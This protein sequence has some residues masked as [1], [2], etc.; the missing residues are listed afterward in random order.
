MAYKRKTFRG[1]MREA[2]TGDGRMNLD[3]AVQREVWGESK[4]KKK[5]SIW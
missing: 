4:R 5:I 2:L 1:D 3:T